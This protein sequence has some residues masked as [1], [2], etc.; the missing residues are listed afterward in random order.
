MDGTFTGYASLFGVPDLGRDVVAPGAFAA[1]LQRRGIAGVRMLWQHDP[2][3]P[4]GRWLSIL[5]DARGLRVTGRLNLAV[6][7]AR[8]IAAL[9][10]DGSL[11]GLSIGFRTLRA[12]PE[13][14]LR[15]LAAVDLWEISLVTFPL[16]AGARVAPVTRP[17][18]A[19][20]SG[21]AR[22]LA[23]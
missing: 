23:A 13:G 4:I 11:D 6:Q 18:A 2:A 3:E 7:R 17:L 19:E 21:L 12:V 16:Q 20:I 5:E 8:E 9:M 10:E 15:R 14:R 1:S 22:R